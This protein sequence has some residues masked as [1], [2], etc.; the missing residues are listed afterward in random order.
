M[1][2]SIDKAEE[3]SFSNL[4]SHWLASLP[5]KWSLAILGIILCPVGILCSYAACIAVVVA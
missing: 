2:N 1:K 4:F 3:I 5:G